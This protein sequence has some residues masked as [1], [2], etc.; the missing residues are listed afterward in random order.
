MT[1]SA[2]L[3]RGTQKRGRRAVCGC[4]T[5]WQTDTAR[6]DNFLEV[7]KVREPPDREEVEWGVLNGDVLLKDFGDLICVRLEEEGGKKRSLGGLD[8]QTP[9]EGCGRCFARTAECGPLKANR[10]ASRGSATDK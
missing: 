6:A 1:A 3:V 2:E 9:R 7:Q 4:A 10:G 8:R 5:Q